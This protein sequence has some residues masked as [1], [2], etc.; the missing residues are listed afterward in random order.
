[1]LS[2]P[3]CLIL[4]ACWSEYEDVFQSC[5][6]QKESRLKSVF[7]SVSKRNWRLRNR[8]SKQR[9]QAPKTHRQTIIM[10]LDSLRD[11]QS[12]G[13]VAWACL[14]VT[15]NYDL[16][17]RTCVEWSSSIHRYGC[18]R[19]YAAARLLRIWKKKGVDLQGSIFN[20]L[21]ACSDIPGLQKRDVYRLLAELVRSR[22][23]SVSKYLQW[24][25][26]RGTLDGHHEFHSVSTVISKTVLQVLTDIGWSLRCLLAIRAAFAGSAISRSQFAKHAAENA[27][28][29]F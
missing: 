11:N 25:I 12:F 26:A 5:L 2:A 23:L 4:P 15:D 24:L 20:F 18:F 21:A 8:A 29:H 16:L 10:Y 14:R 22:H 3:A 19:A 27:G 28:S 7:D 6:D 9:S 13:R 1:M 17:I